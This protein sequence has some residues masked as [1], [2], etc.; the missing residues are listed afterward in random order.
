MHAGR[1]AYGQVDALT[2]QLTS[3]LLDDS[4]RESVFDGTATSV[5][6]L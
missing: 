1:A 5:Y 2:G 3:S 4:E 6:D